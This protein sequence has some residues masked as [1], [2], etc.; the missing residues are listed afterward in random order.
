M[1][2]Q[3]KIRLIREKATPLAQVESV[4]RKN[5][6]NDLYP[7]SKISVF[8]RKYA[9]NWKEMQETNTSVVFVGE[10]GNG[11]TYYSMCIANY[12]ME[13]FISVCITS[14]TE[15]INMPIEER[16]GFLNSLSS[17]SLLVLD[18]LGTERK[19]EYANEI[20]YQVI[21]SRYACQKPMICTTNYSKD[22]IVEKKIAGSERIFDRLEE[23]A[24]F[25]ECVGDSQRKQIG[26]EK[27]ERAAKI[28]YGN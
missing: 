6:E 5:F 17:Y 10:F 14:I 28:L 19:N 1:E 15:I 21:N 16:S 3:Q 26:K 8:A 2:R 4:K 24:I 11:K 9:E 12:L 25:V 7:D 23:M 13:R 20:L 22:E 27:R 18:D